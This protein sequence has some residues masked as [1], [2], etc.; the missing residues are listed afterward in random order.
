M[1]G[2]TALLG[3]IRESGEEMAA[4]SSEKSP[5]LSIVW[6]CRGETGGLVAD[7]RQAVMGN[8]WRS[9]GGFPQEKGPVRTGGYCYLDFE[10]H[11]GHQLN[12]RPQ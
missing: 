9:P 8:G 1:L 5:A 7:C 4:W 10:P 2:C 3:G 12:W 11:F 6:N